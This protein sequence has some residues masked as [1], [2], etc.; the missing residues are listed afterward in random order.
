MVDDEEENEDENGIRFDSSL[1]DVVKA[2]PGSYKIETVRPVK[3]NKYNKSKIQHNPPQADIT[4]KILD[5]RTRTTV[6]RVKRPHLQPK[7]LKVCEICGNSYKY[8]HALD[9]HMRR[10]RGEKPFACE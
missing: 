10:H 6:I 4:T 1:D 9:S 8:R 7:P 5:D 3:G 2:Q